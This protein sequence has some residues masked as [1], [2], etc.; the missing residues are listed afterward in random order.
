M[1]AL[2]R[3]SLSAAASIF[4]NAAGVSLIPVFFRS[5]I[6]FLSLIGFTRK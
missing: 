6:V 4:A 2:D 3:P 1:A 5:F